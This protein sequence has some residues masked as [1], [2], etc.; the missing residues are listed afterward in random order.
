MNLLRSILFENLGLKLI[1]LLLS[2]LVYFN[3]F[4]DRPAT[5]VVTFPVEIEG[6]PDSLALMGPHPEPVEAELRGTGKQIIRLRLTEPRIRISVAGAAVGRFERAIAEADLP[7]GGP[8]APSVERLIGPRMVQLQIDRRGQKLV[9][10]AARVGGVPAA[11]LT[12]E[13][14]LIV[15]PSRVH[16]SGPV[17]ALAVLDSLVLPVLRID[18][19][20]DTVRAQFTPASLPDGCRAD[21]ATV[22]VLV[23]LTRTAP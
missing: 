12:W 11:G 15:Q 19:R 23:P 13:G 2:L 4:T 7:L 1:A 5:E 22:R 10:V 9:P 16:V 8:G 6:L 17:K 18:G 3:A 14:D 21:P 20:R